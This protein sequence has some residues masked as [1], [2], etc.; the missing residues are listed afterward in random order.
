MLHF[1]DKRFIVIIHNPMHEDENNFVLQFLICL[2]MPCLPFQFCPPD[3]GLKIPY[4]TEPLSSWN[5]EFK[6]ILVQGA[7]GRI[8]TQG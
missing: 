3:T 4:F 8:L 5:R 6:I 2:S 1:T 7:G